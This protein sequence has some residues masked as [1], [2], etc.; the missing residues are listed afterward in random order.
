MADSTSHMGDEQKKTR[1]RNT[2]V[3]VSVFVVLTVIYALIANN[4]LI[5]DRESTKTKAQLNAKVYANEIQT[6]FSRGIDV[7]EALEQAII[8]SDGHIDDFQEIA[9][10]LLNDYVGSIQI[11]PDGVVTEIVPMEG[12]EAGLIDLMSDPIRGPSCEYARD[13]DTVTFQGPFE[14][15]QGGTGIAIRNPVFIKDEEGKSEFWGFAIVIIKSSAIFQDTFDAL[16][17]FGYDYVLTEVSSPLSSEELVVEASTESIAPPVSETFEIGACTWRIDVAPCNG[18]RTSTQQMLFSITGFM[19]VVLCTVLV[20]MLLMADSH[21]R[22]LNDLVETDHL[23][24]ILNRTGFAN[25]CKE[26]FDAHPKG[27]ATEAILDIDDFK[28]INDLHGHSVGDEAL[29]NLA[30]NLTSVFGES[31]YVARTGGDEFSILLP[32]MTAEEAQELIRKAVDMDQTFVGSDGKSYTYTISIGYAD[33]PAQAEVPDDLTRIVDGALYN[34]KLNG[35][36]GCQRYECGMVAKSR[37]QLGFTQK[38][39]IRY[40]PGASFICHAEDTKLLY[41]NDQLLSL[42]ECDNFEDF[43]A[44]SHGMFQ[45]IIHKDDFERVMTERSIKQM[46]AKPGG[47]ITCYFRIVTKTGVERPMKAQ[48][49][50]RNHPTYGDLFFVMIMEADGDESCTTCGTPPDTT[51]A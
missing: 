41:V 19:F 51:S 47:Y 13:N 50:F 23:T 7:T 39:L 15:N 3:L 29:V 43:S 37:Q 8:A 24:G 30:K 11:A 4:A 26:F 45:N 20:G 18:W 36:H 31:G 5:L 17:S 34:V 32:L 49:R 44:Y 12:N 40:L 9:D 27:P 33:Y 46:N 48:A 28:L 38:E 6:D 16:S 21:R 10:N 25:R 35:K 1:Q 14:L 2:I 42:L 22:R